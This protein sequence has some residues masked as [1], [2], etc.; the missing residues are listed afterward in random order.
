MALSF[1]EQIKA[2]SKKALEQIDKRLQ[3]IAFN[4]FMDIVMETTVDSGLLCNNWYPNSGADFSS[5]IN[6]LA[7]KSGSGSKARIYAQLGKGTFL[8]K[9]GVMTMANNLSYAYEIEY[10]GPNTGKNYQKPQGM[11]R[12]SVDKTFGKIQAGAL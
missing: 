8:G 7:D 11:V 10:A 3:R 2:N 5:E 4:L 1:S 6:N 12:V 9:D